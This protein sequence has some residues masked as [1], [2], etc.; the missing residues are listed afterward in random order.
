VKFCGEGRNQLLLHRSGRESQAHT[1]VVAYPSARNPVRNMGRVWRGPDGIPRG[2]TP[3][4]QEM[5][6]DICW[7]RSMSKP[8]AQA[9]ECSGEAHKG[10]YGGYIDH[11]FVCIPYWGTYPIC[12]EHGEK[13][14]ESGYCRT[15]RKYYYMGEG[16]W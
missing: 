14:R 5:S 2:Q 3:R 8:P 7:E 12:P 9:V 15:C 11:C 1:G 10:P 4:V 6:E 16:Q 13:L